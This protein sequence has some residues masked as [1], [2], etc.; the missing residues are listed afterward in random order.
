M[1]EDRKEKS[2]LIDKAR[3]DDLRDSL[4]RPDEPPLA[5]TS[6]GRFLYQLLLSI[7]GFVP[8]CN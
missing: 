8:R 2:G 1:A 6:P 7:C 4:E 5:S 3:D